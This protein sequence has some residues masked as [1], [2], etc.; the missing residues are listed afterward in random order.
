MVSGLVAAALLLTIP[1]SAA[2]PGGMVVGEVANI[3]WD[4]V[5]IA[6]ALRAHRLF[7]NG[8]AGMAATV[9]GVVGM[10]LTVLGLLAVVT[11]VASSVGIAPVTAL[12]SA[13]IGVWIVITA[14]LVTATHLVPSSVG[15]LG[16]VAGAS[17]VV[18]YVL[19]LVGGFPTSTDPAAMASWSPLTIV[20]AMLSLLSIPL[21]AGWAIWTARRLPRPV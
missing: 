12:G 8:R 16:T 13:L 11:G 15:W 14:R 3:V 20:A 4:F 10:I 17:T 5:L 1:I 2:V 9:V 18:T 6:V 19:L 21:Y 7:G